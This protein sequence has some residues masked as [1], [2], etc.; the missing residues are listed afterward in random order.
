MKLKHL[1]FAALLWLVPAIAAAASCNDQSY[2]SGEV[3]YDAGSATCNRAIV[4][5]AGALTTT[6]GGAGVT[7]DQ[8]QGT[9][10]AATT[11]V[12][13]PVYIAG[14]DGTAVRP[15]PVAQ[16]GSTAPGGY[17]QVGGVDGAGVGRR[18]LLDATGA[19]LTQDTPTATATA[20]VLPVATTTGST[21]FKAS[22]G[23]L[24]ATEI[25]TGA[26]AGFLMVFNATAVPADGAVTPVS[27][28]AVAANTT[29]VR[30]FIPPAA[31]SVGISVGFSTTGC[32]TKTAAAVF[33]AASFK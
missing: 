16:A 31:L 29:V 22:A 1:F 19:I 23:N 26:S 12:G 9:A 8:V 30:T 17:L 6:S 25:T 21:A 27:C 4:T 18:V 2:I 7:S 28:V 11:P 14:S 13:N 32:A 5:S 15:V 24:Y 20:G 3:R 33:I 10:A